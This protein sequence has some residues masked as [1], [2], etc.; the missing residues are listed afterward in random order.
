MNRFGGLTL[1]SGLA[2]VAAIVALTQPASADEACGAKGQK[3][4][5][6]QGWMEEN[7]QGPF[8][9]KDFKKLEAAFAKVATMSPDPKWN[10]GDKGWAKISEKAA[11]AAKAGDF[12][13]LR[14]TCKS[15]HKTWRKQYRKQHRLKPVK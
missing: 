6:L 9:K 11:A 3:S 15:C 13:A 7:V 5:P 14:A 4:C 1:L 2:A 12:K 8:E 10:E